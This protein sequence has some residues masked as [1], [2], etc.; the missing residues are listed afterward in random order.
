MVAMTMAECPGHN[1]DLTRRFLNVFARSDAIFLRDFSS[2]ISPEQRT[3][4]ALFGCITFSQYCICIGKHLYFTEMHQLICGTPFSYPKSNT[5]HPS[6]FPNHCEP[7]KVAYKKF[8]MVVKKLMTPV[9]DQ[10]VNKGFKTLQYPPKIQRLF[11]L[12]SWV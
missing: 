11:L 8:K 1:V 5:I 6:P 3:K 4:F 12:S 9:N 10:E 7:R 2:E